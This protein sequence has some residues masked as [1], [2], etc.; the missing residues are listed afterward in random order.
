M[1]SYIHIYRGS[2]E[3]LSGRGGPEG[4]T[5][6]PEGCSSGVHTRA[7]QGFEF[8]RASKL[9]PKGVH[10]G[11]IGGS[12]GYIGG[13]MVLCYIWRPYEVQGQAY[14]QAADR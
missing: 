7:I 11:S 1:G 10:W 9:G 14:R 2:I 3:G 8:H 5:W 13:P 6:F 4:F 12:I